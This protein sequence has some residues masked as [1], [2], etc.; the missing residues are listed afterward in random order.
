VVGLFVAD[1]PFL[2]GFIYS[3]NTEDCRLRALYDGN[4]SHH[5]FFY[6]VFMLFLSIFLYVYYLYLRY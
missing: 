6:D 5:L 2:F 1:Y 3:Y 4:K